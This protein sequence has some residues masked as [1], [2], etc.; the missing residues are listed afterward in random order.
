[1]KEHAPPHQFR[2]RICG[3]LDW[4]CGFCGHL[5][6]SKVTRTTWRVRCTGKEC[7]RWFAFG[8]TFHSLPRA[9]RPPIPPPDITF[10]EAELDQWESGGPVNRFVDEEAHE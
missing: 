7:R 3:T 2:A 1:M 4:L 5:N 10:P 6:R 8:T 9:N